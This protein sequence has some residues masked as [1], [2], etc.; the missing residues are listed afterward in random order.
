MAAGAGTPQVP[1]EG[2]EKRLI[3]HSHVYG[4]LAAC[5]LLSGL[6]NGLSAAA[7]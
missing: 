1:S 5:L 2:G 6:R 3:K 4:A 7:P